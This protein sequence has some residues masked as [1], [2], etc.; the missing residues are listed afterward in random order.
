MRNLFRCEVMTLILRDTGPEIN[1]D[2]GTVLRG[3][4]NLF[5]LDLNKVQ[6]EI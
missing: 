1:F 3:Y 4:L 5:I 2:A 6:M